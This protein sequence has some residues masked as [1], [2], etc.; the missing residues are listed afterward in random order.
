MI[1][2][3]IMLICTWGCAALFFL[4]GV[5]AAHRRKPMW[6]WSGSKVSPAEISDIPAYNRANGRMWKLY[7]IPY[8]LSG[9]LYFWSPV[10]STI[11]L[12]A[13]AMFGI[14][15]LVLAYRRIER[16]YRIEEEE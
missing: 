8:W 16:R 4:L 15:V 13:G 10:V 6:F 11:V 7:S 14:I 3:I 9:G 12:L 5:Y 1:D 2:T